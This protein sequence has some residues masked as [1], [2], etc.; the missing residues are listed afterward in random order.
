M[1]SKDSCLIALEVNDLFM[2][3]KLEMSMLFIS[4]EVLSSVS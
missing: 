1:K 2:F 4:G 3:L